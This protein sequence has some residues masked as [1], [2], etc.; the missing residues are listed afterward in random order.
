[1]KSSYREVYENKTWIKK[2]IDEI[3][4]TLVDS[5]VEDLTEI[6]NNMND[7]LNKKPRIKIKETIE[8]MGR[9]KPGL[10]KS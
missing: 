8:N 7:F 6:L 9:S 1:M 2:K 5:K 4:N 3:I 10:E